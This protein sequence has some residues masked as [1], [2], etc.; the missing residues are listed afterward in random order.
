MFKDKKQTKNSR[1][2]EKKFNACSRFVACSLMPFH[3]YALSSFVSIIRI[4]Y[5]AVLKPGIFMEYFVT[6]MWVILK[7][8]SNL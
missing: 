8:S 7:G 6:L 3:V 1:T 2:I 4:Q 5:K